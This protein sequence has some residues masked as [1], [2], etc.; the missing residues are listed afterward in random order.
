MTRLLPICS[1]A[2]AIMAAVA[3]LETC[4]NNAQ[5]RS[6]TY[7]AEKE[8]VGNHSN[9]WS[10]QDKVTELCAMV[11]E[12][13]AQAEAQRAA[14]L[15]HEKAER[16]AAAAPVKPRGPIPEQAEFKKRL[17]EINLMKEKQP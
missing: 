9:A 13:K 15:T 17:G 12:C 10:L 8:W 3:A 14:R 5:A 6:S 2:V 7:S 16:E 1:L 11:P 4:S